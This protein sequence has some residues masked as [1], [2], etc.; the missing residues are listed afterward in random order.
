[1]GSKL[2]VTPLDAHHGAPGDWAFLVTA[3]KTP[4]RP[5]VGARRQGSGLL[6]LGW[7]W[8]MSIILCW[9]LRPTLPQLGACCSG[10]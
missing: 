1:M 4:P 8:H 7:W 6:L 9:S 2:E 3:F 10:S 5:Q